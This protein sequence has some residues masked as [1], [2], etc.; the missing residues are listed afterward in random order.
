MSIKYIDDFHKLTKDN[1]KHFCK[2]IHASVFMIEK[3]L[4]QKD[5]EYKESD[6]N[7]FMNMTNMFRHWKGSTKKIELDITQKWIVACILGIKTKDK[8][9]DWVRYFKECRI[10]VAKK[11]GKSVLMALFALWGLLFDR[12]REGAEIYCVATKK[13][14]SKIVLDN[15]RVYRKQH[16]EISKLCREVYEAGDKHIFCDDN[17]G[18][19]KAMSSSKEGLQGTNSTWCLFDEA[20]EVKDLTVIEAVRT[21]MA[22]RKQPMLVA[23]STAGV[24]PNSAYHQMYSQI[25]IMCDRKKFDDKMRVFFAVFELDVL[26]SIDDRKVWIK[27]NPALL[28]GR[29]TLDHLEKEYALAK[30]GD[31]ESSL[32]RFIAFHMNRSCDEAQTFYDSETVNKMFCEYGLDKTRGQMAFG[33]VDLSSYADFM[34]CTAIFPFRHIG[35]EDI[36]D[37]YVLQQYFKAEN[38]LEKDSE[39]DKIAYK[40][41]LETKSKNLLC[42]ELLKL[43]QGDANH[44]RY[45]ADWFKMLRDDYDV[46]FQKI[47]YDPEYYPAPFLDEIQQYSNSGKYSFTHEVVNFSEN[48]PTRDR[49]ILTKVKGKSG[50]LSDLI[51]LSKM[52]LENKRLKVDSHNKMLG[53]CMSNIK[54][55]VDNDNKM[56]IVKKNARGRIDGIMSLLYA[57]RAYDCWKEQFKHDIQYGNFNKY[58]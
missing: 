18:T 17:N 40:N 13:S 49:G 25:E 46:Y 14:Q 53:Y 56:A 22:T 30:M 27:A 12:D 50:A 58:Q 55:T 2:K 57:M 10:F 7:A 44:P 42:V 33:G 21:G 16:K 48:P 20:Q 45:A 38:R 36:Y 35:E 8:D 9:G 4:K 24:T 28:D 37:F 41:F 47:G 34:V 1:P 6:V 19:I 51:K 11:F 31:G 54:V 15:C 52:H 32:P 39:Q 29:P 26:D 5:I 43:C 23:M 3:L